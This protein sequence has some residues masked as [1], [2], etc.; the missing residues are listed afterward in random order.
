MFVPDAIANQTVEA[1]LVP[2]GLS[3]LAY[4]ECRCS[5]VAPADVVMCAC[6]AV[7]AAGLHMQ[8][9]SAMAANVATDVR[10]MERD[11]EDT[12]SLEARRLYLRTGLLTLVLVGMPFVYLAAALLALRARACCCADPG[13]A[14]A[15]A[16]SHAD[17]GKAQ[18]QRC[19]G[20]GKRSSRIQH[21]G[22]PV[23][24]PLRLTV[25]K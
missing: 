22:H 17:D 19:C 5:L 15:A 20:R 25:A 8:M 10:I 1:L 18:S 11:W 16:A 13:S 23:S 3:V 14:A 7:F 2:E 4:C 6:C 9:Q 12:S 21:D 24:P